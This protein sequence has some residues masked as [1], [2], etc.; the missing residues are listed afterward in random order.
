MVNAFCG[1]QKLRHHHLLAGTALVTALLAG[2]G[3]ANA[4]P[5]LAPPVGPIQIHLNDDEQFSASNDITGPNNAAPYS[6]INAAGT[7]GNWGIVEI[8]SIQQ[9]TVQSPIGSDI[10]GGGPTLFVNGQNG[11]EQILGIFYGIHIDSSGPPALASGG[12]LDLYGFT[13]SS[14]NVGTEISSSANLAKRTAQNQYTGFTCASGNTANCTFLAQ[15]DFV[16]GANTAADMTSTIVSP[17]NPATSDG[18]AQS[19]LSVN[20]ADPG[21]WSAAL[22]D[23]FFTLDP[24]NNPLPDTPDVRLSNSFAH[25]GATAW[26]GPSDIVGLIS[27]DP[28]RAAPLPEPGSL[29]LLGTAL[30]GLA[31]L[32]RVR[33]RKGG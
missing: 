23:N 18:T 8:S 7:E 17:V 25:G 1:R 16:Y 32:A 12:V 30:L 2:S 22:N 33:G 4:T 26:S 13:G 21:A 31:S 15:L 20:T 5:F 27:S 6:A 28:G 9:G 29:A 10:Q 14:Q 3:L 24:N 11:G 19:Y